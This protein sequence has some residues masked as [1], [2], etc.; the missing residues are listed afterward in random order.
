MKPTIA[1]TDATLGAIVT[2]IDLTKLDEATWEIVVT[3]ATVIFPYHR[4]RGY[5]CKWEG[6][7]VNG[8]G[9]MGLH[10]GK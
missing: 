1:S 4:F 6:F 2:D 3:I 7:K 10:Q 9:I 8:K 5:R